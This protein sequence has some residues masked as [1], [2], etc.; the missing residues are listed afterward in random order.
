MIK[1][2][3]EDFSFIKDHPD[4]I[5]L[6]LFGS[7]VSNQNNIRSDIDI[8]LV[9]PN[10]NLYEIYKYV[11][12][13]LKSNQDK[14]DIRFFEELPLYI[15]GEI[16]ED[17]KIIFCKDEPSLFEYFYNFIKLWEDQKLK[18]RILSL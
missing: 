14:Y 15:Q 18:L 2:I 9:V 10:K 4:I 8:C 6:I 3:E 11:M 17:G 5:A 12:Q 16:I 7:H 1:Q 13:N